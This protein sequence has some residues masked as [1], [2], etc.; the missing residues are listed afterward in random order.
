MD[1]PLEIAKMLKTKWDLG[2][3]GGVLI[4][5][6]IPEEYSLNEE[7]MNKA[8]DEA[9]DEAIEEIKDAE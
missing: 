9:I 5:N 2:L 1:T 3:N 6:P 4:T 7:V 8:I